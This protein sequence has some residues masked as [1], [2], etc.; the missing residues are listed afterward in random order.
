MAIT[1]S[2]SA[3]QVVLDAGRTFIH[4]SRDKMRK[5]LAQRRVYR[6]TQHELSRLS[7]RELADLGIARS[8]INQI[9]RNAANG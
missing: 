6:V 2:R 3:L 1:R 5:A 8:N 4:Q 7:D 9:A